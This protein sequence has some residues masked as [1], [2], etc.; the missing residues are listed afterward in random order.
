MNGEAQRWQVRTLGLLLFMGLCACIA[1][2]PGYD[3]G[4]G[5]AYVGGYYGPVG[6][7]YNGWGPGYYVAPPRRGERRPEPARPPV[8][9][10][11]PRTYQTPSIPTRPRDVRRPAPRPT[12]PPARHQRGH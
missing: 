10:P 6:H 9:R 12:P 3:G 7:D 2:G 11:A 8:Y 5:V 1:T 4:V